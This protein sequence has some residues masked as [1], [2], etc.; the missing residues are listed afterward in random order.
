MMPKRVTITQLH[1]IFAHTNYEYLHKMIKTRMV[2]GYDLD[3]NSVSEF[4][5]ACIKA[6][7]SQK[8]FPKVSTG[9]KAQAYGDKVVCDLWEPAK[10]K[11]LTG[12]CYTMNFQDK[13]THEECKATSKMRAYQATQRLGR[14]YNT[15]TK[16]YDD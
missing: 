3:E 8:P 5:K 10:V 12:E 13:Y 16:E 14:S 6:K 2:T 7:M 9:E 1:N 11:A 15:K 4:C